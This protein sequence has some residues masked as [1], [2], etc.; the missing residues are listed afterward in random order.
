VPEAPSFVEEGT[1]VSAFSCG[2]DSF[3]LLFSLTAFTSAACFSTL[4][5]SKLPPFP[6][7]LTYS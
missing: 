5:V 4:A 1:F 3:C 2:A 7:E 6:P